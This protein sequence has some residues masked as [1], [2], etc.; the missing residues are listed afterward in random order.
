MLMKNEVTTTSVA[1]DGIPDL[2]ILEGIIQ[3]AVDHTPLSTVIA[4]LEGAEENGH[5]SL[6]P[7][8][9]E[10]LRKAAGTYICYLWHQAATKR[11][12][13]QWDAYPII[14]D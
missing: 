6:S 14:L 12:V 10:Q 11:S 7:E 1:F 3:A 13:A 2:E 5:D 8:T 4:I 9:V